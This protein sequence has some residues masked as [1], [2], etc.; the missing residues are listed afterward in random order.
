MPQ[1][2]IETIAYSANIEHELNDL[3]FNCVDEVAVVGDMSYRQDNIAGFRMEHIKIVFNDLE[4]SLHYM[5]SDYTHSELKSI[6]SMIQFYLKLFPYNRLT[7]ANQEH[8][9]IISIFKRDDTCRVD[10]KLFSITFLLN[11]WKFC[12]NDKLLKDRLMTST[13]FKSL[14][15]VILSAFQDMFEDI[16]IKK[17]LMVN[18]NLVKQVLQNQTNF[19]FT[20]M[21]FKNV[22]THELDMEFAKHI[23]DSNKFRVVGELPNYVSSVQHNEICVAGDIRV[24]RNV[25]NVTKLTD[26]YIVIHNDSLHLLDEIFSVS[27]TPEQLFYLKK[28][29]QLLR[30]SDNCFESVHSNHIK[31]VRPNNGRKSLFNLIPERK[32]LHFLTGRN[33]IV[34]STQVTVSLLMGYT[35]KSIAADSFE[36]AY[37]LAY[38][39]FISKVASHL[40]ILPS[41]VTDRHITTLEMMHY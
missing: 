39:A 30:L 38:D 3:S 14:Q 23:R 32:A 4:S 5:F 29:F 12:I 34:L 8:Q 37:N 18:N 22:I 11:G 7:A 19:S 28:M 2:Q 20:A 1:S 13:S 40:S 33:S 26:T 35:M 21:R 41:E 9:W 15:T 24:S 16:F 6:H 17:H 10:F 31:I 27:F 36:A 25:L